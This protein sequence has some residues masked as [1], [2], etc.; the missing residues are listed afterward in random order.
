MEKMVEH[1]T[2][3]ID[4]RELSIHSTIDYI[5]RRINRLTNVRDSKNSLAIIELQKVRNML[6]QK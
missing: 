2:Q 3:P 5:N 1:I 6:E 4:L